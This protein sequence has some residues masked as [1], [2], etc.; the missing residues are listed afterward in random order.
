MKALFTSRHT[1]AMR[2]AIPP[3][4]VDAR[5]IATAP[6]ATR[7]DRGY[8]AASPFDLHARLELPGD[9]QEF[10]GRLGPT[11]RHNFRYYRRKFELAGHV[12]APALSLDDLQRIATELCTSSQIPIGRAAIGRAVA[13]MTACE[14]PWAS[15]LRHRDGRWLSVAGG[16]FSG[17]SAFLF[18]QVN[19]D[20]DHERASLSVVHRAHLI[21]TLIGRGAPE[22]VFWSGVGPPLSR[23]A[24][25]MPAMMACLDRRTP[26]WRLVRSLIGSSQRWMPK[27]IAADVRWMASLGLA[28]ESP[29]A[30]ALEV[31]AKGRGNAPRGTAAVTA[32]GGAAS[33][34]SR[35]RWHRGQET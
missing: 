30:A 3:G 11:T 34:L 6:F 20:R 22:L 32:G 28:P 19:C 7:F 35:M 1:H 33:R 31:A 17:D 2:L 9:Y 25:P 18:M 8:G 5:A 12:Y 23:Y 26:G 27:R 14:R 21:E 15:G 29:G 24:V 16:W 13:L 10:L 4:G